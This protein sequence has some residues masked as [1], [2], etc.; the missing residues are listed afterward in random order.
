[1]GVSVQPLLHCVLLLRLMRWSYQHSRTIERQ[2]SA[3]KGF[4]N[5]SIERLAL[6][7]RPS[8]RLCPSSRLQFQRCSRPYLASRRYRRLLSCCRR[9]WSNEVA[10]RG[11]SFDSANFTV[12]WHRIRMSDRAECAKRRHRLRMADSFREPVRVQCVPIAGIIVPPLSP[13]LQP[14]RRR[15]AKNSFADARK[16]FS[17]P[18]TVRFHTYWMDLR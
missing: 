7:D 5:G 8:A 1:M 4:M 2:I 18:Q 3:R 9:R 11:K 14:F 13:D 17:A 16:V 15:F 6:P 10:L 12:Q